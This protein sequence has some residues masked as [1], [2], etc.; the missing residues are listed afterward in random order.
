MGNICNTP[1]TPPP[2]KK[3]TGLVEV[4]V[5]G[6]CDLNKG[7]DEVE[8]HLIHMIQHEIMKYIQVSYINQCMGDVV[9]LYFSLFTYLLW[10]STS[11][12]TPL[13]T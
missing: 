8:C 1:V 4:D 9:H 10:P 2:N 6:H 3:K 11:I 7:F 12:P 5:F 13:L